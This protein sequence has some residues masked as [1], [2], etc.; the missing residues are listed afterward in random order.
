MKMNKL[1][2]IAMAAAV[3]GLFS[4]S[5]LTAPAHAAGAAHEAKIKCENSSACKGQGACKTAKNACKGQN[6][7]K[8]QGF[9]MQK[10]QAD[11]AAAQ[12][13]AQS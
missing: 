10:T 2:G 12:K 11:C 13:S 5:V 3:A 4:A 9:T 8:G 1:N 7:C 6:G